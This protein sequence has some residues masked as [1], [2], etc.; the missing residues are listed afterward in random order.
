MKESLSTQ[1]KALFCKELYPY[2]F[3]L[4]KKT[5]F[6]VIN[7][8]VQTL[9]LCKTN[10][11][12]SIEFD[13]DPLSL[14]IE[15]L[16]CESLYN[17]A[18]FRNRGWWACWPEV[19][20]NAFEDILF[21]FRTHVKPIF[22]RGIDSKSAYDELIRLEKSIFTGVPGGIIDDYKFARLC[23]QAQDYEKAYQHLS[24][25]VKTWD[26]AYPHMLAEHKKRGADA[27]PDLAFNKFM[28]EYEELK[29]DLRR[30]S[31]PDA[32]Y[33]KKLVAQN[34]AISIENLKHPKYPSQRR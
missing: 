2:G 8:V 4:Y 16:Y 25:I 11:D 31:I 24:V 1:Y 28:L 7:D 18:T 30:L 23:I 33:F 19:E 27:G 9:M 14:P 5:F 17:I 3:R 15:D 10:T 32:E 34:Q 26:E 22:E 20:E 6:R 21:L 13:I 12:F 29:E